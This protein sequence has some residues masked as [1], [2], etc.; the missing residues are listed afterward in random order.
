MKENGAL[1]KEGSYKHRTINM[2]IIGKTYCQKAIKSML[3][4]DG[5]NACCNETNEFVACR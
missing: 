1:M 3:I 2:V 5:K 4:C